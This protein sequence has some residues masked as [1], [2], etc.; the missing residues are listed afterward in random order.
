MKKALSIITTIMILFCLFAIPA[1]A[2]NAV[3]VENITLNAETA[4]VAI[5]KSFSL[6]ATIQPKNATVK[7][8]EW[9]SSDESIA[10]VK[11]GNV[12]G[13]ALG[14]VTITAKATDESS[15]SAS[16]EI[17]VIQP[18]KKVALS[19]SKISLAPGTTWKLK[20]NIDP[21]TASIKDIIWTSSNE[22]VAK[23]DENGIVTAIGKGT[24]KITATAADGSKAKAIATVKVEKFDLVFTSKAPQIVEYYYG[25]GSFKIKGSVK[26]GNVSIPNIDTSMFVMMI[27]G[28]QREEVSVTP[29]KPGTDVVTIKVGSKKYKYTVFVAPEVF[30]ENTA[31]K[32]TETI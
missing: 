14:T 21:Q 20:A 9:I 1:S 7:K 11:N 27:G 16:A 2:A 15:I 3:P 24:A 13:I 18:V 23:V 25:S 19:D 6:K 26:N 29:V 22:K 32:E 8:V 30:E 17:T 31:T 28:K 5:G 12:K 10:T 4:T